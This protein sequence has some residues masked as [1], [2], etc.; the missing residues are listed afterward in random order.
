MPAL[1]TFTWWSNQVLV[2]GK[3]KGGQSKDINKIHGNWRCK[4]STSLQIFELKVVTAKNT[5]DLTVHLGFKVHIRAFKCCTY[6][7]VYSCIFVTQFT[8]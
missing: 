7:M 4:V 3:N 5:H 1:F 2:S 6:R 8:K